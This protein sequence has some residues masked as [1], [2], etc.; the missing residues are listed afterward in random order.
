[1]SKIVAISSQKG[2]V[3]KTTTAINLAACLA[4]HNLKVLLIDADPQCS[5]T[6]GLGFTINEYDYNIYHTIIGTKKTED[7]IINTFIENLD[8]IPSNLGMIGLE[9]MFYNSVE[10]KEYILK[11]IIKP[12][13][14]NYD[15]I[16]IDSPAVLGAITIN[17]FVA[18]DYIIIPVQCEYLAFDTLEESL[19]T[20]SL[21]QKTHNHFLKYKILPT[22]FTTQ[23]SLAKD[24]IF[25]LKNMFD[26]KLIRDE[27]N[28]DYIVI[29]KT[30]QL[31]KAAGY[32]QPIINY[33]RKSIAT[34]AYN[35]L[36]LSL[37]KNNFFKNI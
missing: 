3:G 23:N 16:I 19:E 7:V 1:M 21:I 32:G 14:Q 6:R 13:K 31:A 2:G 20:V 8:F 28:E 36:A 27:D 9:K 15:Y 12:I 4:S 22:M 33:N 30:V 24:V 26:K 29:P 11:N 17:I 5:A 35:N 37:I 25:N 18:S 10:N 34:I